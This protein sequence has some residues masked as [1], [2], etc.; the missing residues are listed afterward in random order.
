MAGLFDWTIKQRIIRKPP[1][2]PEVTGRRSKGR[3]CCGSTRRSG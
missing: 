3:I 2:L 1:E